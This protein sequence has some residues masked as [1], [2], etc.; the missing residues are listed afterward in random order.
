[1]EWYVNFGSYGVFWGMVALGVLIGWLDRQAIARLRRGDWSN[2]AVWWLPGLSL[3][4]VGGSLVEA[5][6]GA[7]AALVVA[8]LIRQYSAGK[9][10]PGPFAALALAGSRPIAAPH[11][12]RSAAARSRSAD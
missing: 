2:F 4:Q 12:L 7:A 1:M 8:L 3:L 10:Q 6:S 9:R 11:T 5:V